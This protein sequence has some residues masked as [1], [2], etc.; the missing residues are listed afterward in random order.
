MIGTLVESYLRSLGQLCTIRHQRQTLTGV[1]RALDPPNQ[2][3]LAVPVQVDD[4][5]G[6]QWQSI[7]VRSTSSRH[8]WPS[9]P[10][11]LLPL[12]RQASGGHHQQ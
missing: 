6:V 11:W 7:R 10:I 9:T 3:V 5:Q 4:Y 2:L 12:D 8:V 1:V